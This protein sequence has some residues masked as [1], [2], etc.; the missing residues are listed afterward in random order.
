[1][2]RGR[3]GALLVTG[4]RAKGQQRPLSRGRERRGVQGREE[5]SLWLCVGMGLTLHA[6]QDIGPAAVHIHSG[7]L[8][9]QGFFFFFASLC[10]IPSDSVVKESAFHFRRHRRYGFSSWNQKINSLK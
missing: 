9:A 2:M 6:Q 8:S 4:T 1:M 7:T 5:R 10:G 3:H